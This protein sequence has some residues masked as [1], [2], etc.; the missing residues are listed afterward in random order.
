MPREE[1]EHELLQLMAEPGWPFSWRHATKDP[2]ALSLDADVTR[3]PG[4]SVRDVPPLRVLRRA[5]SGSFNSSS[6]SL[7]LGSSA[8][9]GGLSRVVSVA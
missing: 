8:S 2:F 9:E 5:A 7:E 6:A 3:Q 4:D 1:L